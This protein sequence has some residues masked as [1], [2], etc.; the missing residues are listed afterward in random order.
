M[1][2][3]YYGNIQTEINNLFHKK[4]DNRYDMCSR[5]PLDIVRCK[6]EVSRNSLRYRGPLIWNSLPNDLKELENA[7]TFKFNLRKALNIINKINFEKEAAAGLLATKKIV[8][9]TFRHVF[10]VLCIFSTSAL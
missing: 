9:F 8:F 5:F 4:E 7:Q 1:H 10:I 6:S 3:V 2:R